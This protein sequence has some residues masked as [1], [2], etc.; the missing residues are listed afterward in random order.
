M[1][2]LTY[3]ELIKMVDYNKND[4]KYGKIFIPNDIFERLKNEEK[5]TKKG[6]RTS[7]YVDVAYSYLYYVTF[8]YRNAKYG[9][10]SDTDS[11]VGRFKEVLGFNHSDKRI[12]LITG[13]N[14]VLEGMGLLRAEPFKKA[15]ITVS[16]NNGVVDFK[17]VEDVDYIKIKN[18][19]KFV[20]YPVFALE[21]FGEDEY[22]YGT[23]NA[24]LD[25]ANI[26]NTTELDFRVFAR[27]M[28]NDNLGT[29]AFYIYAFLKWKSITSGKGSIEISHQKIMD[30]TGLTRGKLLQ[31]LDG[32]KKHNL[33]RCVPA[34]FVIGAD[35][36]EGASEYCVN[37][38]ESYTE[39]EKSY[40][41]RKVIKA[42][43][44]DEK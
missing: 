12:N 28:T 7:T 18:K 29:S 2:K 37:E 6:E 34:P 9:V 1:A 23:F 3:E 26:A 15:P 38:I 39:E 42:E 4:D 36:G 13:K 5:L 40:S 27:C 43:V 35:E 10:L 22:G 8:L 24:K 33:I 14:G 44:E 21:R 11:D 17:Y 32:L 31:A 25:D 41:T 19:R 30:S 20:K 16:F